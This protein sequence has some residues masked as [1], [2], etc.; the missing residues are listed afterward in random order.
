[1]LGEVWAQLMKKWSA[2]AI[3]DKVEDND[4]QR[5]ATEEAMRL[6]QMHV[7][8]GSTGMWSFPAADRSWS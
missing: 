4:V 6:G 7:V 2:E 5:G 8:E 1:M 3:G